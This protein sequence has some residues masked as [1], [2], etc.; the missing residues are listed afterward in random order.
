MKVANEP[1]TCEVA[2]QRKLRIPPVAVAVRATLDFPASH[3]L[4][5]AQIL[6]RERIRIRIWGF[7]PIAPK[8]FNPTLSDKLALWSCFLYQSGQRPREIVSG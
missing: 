6:S 7:L 1:I 8:R 2:Q 4:Q 3:Q 5:F